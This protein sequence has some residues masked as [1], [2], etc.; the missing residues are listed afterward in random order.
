MDLVDEQHVAIF[1][2][3]EQRREISRLGDDRAGGGAKIDAE[4]ARH[5]LRERRL[6]ETRRPREQ[7]MVERLA[8]RPRRLD[9][10]FEVRADLGLADELAEH[11]RPERSLRLIVVAL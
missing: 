3:G 8:P 4:L 2:I 11:L 6:A 9:E 7:N 5:D 1:E 10:H